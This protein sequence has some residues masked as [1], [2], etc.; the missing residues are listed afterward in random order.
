MTRRVLAAIVLSA[1]LA[2]C[3]AQEAPQPTPSFTGWVPRPATL[4]TEYANCLKD[5]AVTVD[6]VVGAFV[7]V[8]SAAQAALDAASP[9]C[10]DN[11]DR[12]HA[13]V[14]SNSSR[15]IPDQVTYTFIHQVRNCMITNFG[16]T[17]HAEQT[18]LVMGRP[19]TRQQFDSCVEE[20]R[21]YP[22]PTDS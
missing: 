20:I 2:G 9:A 13:T 8:P 7:L 6:A 21:A 19:I 17:L 10:E 12:Y 14:L 15:V 4:L 18:V 11:L 5:H 3:T 22:T 16:I 1:A